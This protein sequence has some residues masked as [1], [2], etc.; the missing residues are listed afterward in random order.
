MTPITW[1]DLASGLTAEQ[2]DSLTR[3]EQQFG[4]HPESNLVL[5]DLAHEHVEGN[6]IDAQFA[7]VPVPAG[8]EHVDHW[9]QTGTVWQREIQ[10][11]SWSVAGVAVWI[12]GYQY[13][14]GRVA[15]F[16]SIDSRTTELTADYGRDVMAA[17][18]EAV[19]EVSRLSGSGAS[20]RTT[21]T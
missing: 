20:I 21:T 17:L 4:T 14:D 5:F 3:Q 2:V 10:G 1:R 13:A 18:A 8:V 12:G 7:H 6:Q 19:E 9:F 16:V 15:A 11:R